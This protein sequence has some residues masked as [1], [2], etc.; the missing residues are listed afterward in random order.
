MSANGDDRALS[1][2]TNKVANVQINEAALDRV[3]DTKWGTPLGF[4]YAKYNAEPRDK[5]APA[6]ES[7]Q[8]QG[9]NSNW[10]AGA[11]KYEWNDDYGE[12]GPEHVELK[13]MLFGDE[14]K[15]EQGEEFSK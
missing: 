9:D 15:V 4:D 11:A 7:D 6:S 1:D 12:V 5:T 2:V 8:P 13:H 14:H 3:K 10:A